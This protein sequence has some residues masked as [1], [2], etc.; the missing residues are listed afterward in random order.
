LRKGREIDDPG[1]GERGNSSRSAFEGMIKVQK[2][3]GK[4]CVPDPGSGEG[5]T[6]LFPFGR[7][8]GGPTTQIRIGERKK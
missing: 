5:E 8:R 1:E 7:V 4:L 3:E 2:K 6:L